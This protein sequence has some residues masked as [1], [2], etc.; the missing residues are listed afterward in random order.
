M[1]L[2]VIANLFYQM[3]LIR[4][5]LPQNTSDFSQ[6]QKEVYDNLSALNWTLWTIF[7]RKMQNGGFCYE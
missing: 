3:D 4:D 7:R 6:E 2:T 1:R 5:S